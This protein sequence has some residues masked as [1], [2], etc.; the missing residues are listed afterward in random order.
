MKLLV[1][2]KTDG[3]VRI[4]KQ[5]KNVEGQLAQFYKLIGTDAIQL[6]PISDYVRTMGYEMYGDEV[7]VLNGKPMNV[8]VNPLFDKSALIYM[9]R[10]GGPAGTMVLV[11]PKR[12]LTD[13]VQRF[14]DYE[15]DDDYK[16]YAAELK[17]AVKKYQEKS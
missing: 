3:K 11:C 12:L 14:V 8:W 9:A 10:Y 1:V 15:D 13:L 6:M 17:K 2:F 7:G 4:C 5:V 16:N